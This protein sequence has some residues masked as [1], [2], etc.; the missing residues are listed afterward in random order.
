MGKKITKTGF[1]SLRGSDFSDQQLD[2]GVVVLHFWG[3]QDKPLREPYGQVGYLDFLYRKYSSKGLKV[4]GVVADAKLEDETLRQRT[5]QSARKFVSFMN[6]SYP[7]LVDNEFYLRKVL[8]DPRAAGARL[9][10]FLVLDKEGKVVHYHVGFYEV[11][12]DRGLEKLD[13]AVSTALGI[14]E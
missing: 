4:F 8:G 10:L 6:V 9:P 14:D 3:Y 7:V 13:K 1:K 2:D 5:L 12:R 11:D